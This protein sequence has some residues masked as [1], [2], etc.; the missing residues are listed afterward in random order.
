MVGFPD[1]YN[2]IL[3]PGVD[4]VVLER[5]FS[6]IVQVIDTIQNDTLITN[7]INNAYEKLISSGNFSWKKFV[8][9]FECQQFNDSEKDLS[10]TETTLGFHYWLMTAQYVKRLLFLKCMQSFIGLCVIYYRLKM[11]FILRTKSIAIKVRQFCLKLA[12]FVFQ[13]LP[14]PMKTFIKGFVKRFFHKF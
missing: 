5:D 12:Y 7:I 6:N 10:G 8:R 1:H 14:I 2:G 9:D 11:T 3:E 13:K 4:Y